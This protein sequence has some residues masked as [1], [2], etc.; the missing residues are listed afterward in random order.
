MNEIKLTL[1]V[2]PNSKKP[3]IERGRNGLK[4]KLS[5]PPVDGK[6]NKEL[7]RVLAA[8][9]GIKK[10]RISIIKG[11]H[12]RNKTVLIQYEKLPASL[13]EFLIDTEN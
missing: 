9:T 12:S 2:V 13:N 11:F 8:F 3:A 6:A 4:I 10:S 1:K 5:A 7:I